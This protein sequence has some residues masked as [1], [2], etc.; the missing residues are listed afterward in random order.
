MLRLILLALSVAAIAQIPAPNIVGGDVPSGASN[1]TT[2]GAIPY[3]SAAGVLNQD[4]PAL[5]W[6]AANNRLG[7]GTNSPDQ[8]LTFGA[9]VGRKIEFY[10]GAGYNIGVEPNVVVVVN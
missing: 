10:Q 4:T 2:V 8:T 5:F 9:S 7:L 1:L 3:V 6:D